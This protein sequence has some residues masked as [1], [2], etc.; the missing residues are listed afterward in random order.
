MDLDI[1]CGRSECLQVVHY[2]FS[3]YCKSKS[4][5]RKKNQLFTQKMW[6]LGC[7]IWSPHL[8][9]YG[10]PGRTWWPPHKESAFFFYQLQSFGFWQLSRT[11]NQLSS[12]F[13]ASFWRAFL[14]GIN[15]RSP[16]KTRR[17]WW[18]EKGILQYWYYSS[19]FFKLME[20]EVKMGDNIATPSGA[21]QQA[22]PKNVVWPPFFPSFL[23]PSSSHYFFRCR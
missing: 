17:A 21:D 9:R 1:C 8:H 14:F 10:H 20:E 22:D 12:F 18:A 2:I 5:W 6:I 23:L 13:S 7:Q 16:F 11:P 4:W 15:G 19:Q 3:R